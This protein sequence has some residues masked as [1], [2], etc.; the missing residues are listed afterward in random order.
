MA[1]FDSF[2]A[3]L[4]HITSVKRNEIWIGL[5]QEKKGSDLSNYFL[6]LRNNRVKDVKEEIPW[7]LTTEKAAR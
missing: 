7:K 2:H 1:S 6:V 5:F 4:A 3:P